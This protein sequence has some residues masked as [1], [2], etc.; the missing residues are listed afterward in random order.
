MFFK[1][2]NKE[3]I[4]KTEKEIA[5]TDRHKETNDFLRSMTAAEKLGEALVLK[6]EWEYKPK[7]KDE[8]KQSNFVLTHNEDTNEI[9]LHVNGERYRKFKCK[10]NLSGSIKFHEGLDKVLGL[11]RD[12]N[13]YDKN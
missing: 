2:T 10:D 6:P 7:N 8:P 12:W 9:T 11:F 1:N 13:F 3:V 4:M 5:E